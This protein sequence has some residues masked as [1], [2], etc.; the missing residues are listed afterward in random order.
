MG[1]T[2]PALSYEVSVP[3][4]ERK[5]VLSNLSSFL[6]G[7]PLGIISVPERLSLECLTVLL[8]SM[9]GL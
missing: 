5:K 2:A 3:A 1:K 7:N 6:A 9:N 4:E 8:L